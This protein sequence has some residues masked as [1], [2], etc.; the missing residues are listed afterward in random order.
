ML[1]FCLCVC[2]SLLHY[3]L[4][5]AQMTRLLTRRGIRVVTAPLLSQGTIG[6]LRAIL[7]QTDAQMLEFCVCFCVEVD[8][9]CCILFATVVMFI[10]SIVPFKPLEVLSEGELFVCVVRCVDRLTVRTRWLNL[11]LSLSSHFQKQ[12][13]LYAVYCDFKFL[14]HYLLYI[15]M[16]N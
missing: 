13:R 5:L 3:W 16:W 7:L 15:Y 11:S 8:V 14:I 9:V 10:Y 1:L 4:Q 6:C 2:L 12:L